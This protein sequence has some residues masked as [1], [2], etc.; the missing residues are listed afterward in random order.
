MGSFSNWVGTDLHETI[1]TPVE[2]WYSRDKNVKD[3]FWEVQTNQR[4]SRKLKK[5][6]QPEKYEIN[7]LIH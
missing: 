7:F 6:Y 3:D 5:Y 4:D 1:Y 2:N